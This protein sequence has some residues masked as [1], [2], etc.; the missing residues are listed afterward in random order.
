M[1]NICDWE[2]HIFHVKL[3]F[4][5]ILEKWYMLG[6]IVLGYSPELDGKAFML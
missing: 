4:I 2:T 3:I 5:T 1:R 6:A